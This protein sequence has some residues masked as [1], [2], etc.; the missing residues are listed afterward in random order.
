MS[1]E[2]DFWVKHTQM[3]LNNT[4]GNNKNWVRLDEKGHTGTNTMKGLIRA[5][6]IHNGI[7]PV[8]GEVG[9]KER[10]AL[11]SMNW[12]TLVSGGD[13]NV[14]TI[15]KQLNNEFLD[16]IGVG[17]CDGII[18]RHTAL[19]LIAA[20]QAAE[21]IPVVEDLNQINFGNKTTERF[22]E[23]KFNRSFKKNMGY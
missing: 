20:L 23:L 2:G 14:R 19:S 12:F 1:S 17:P 5:F 16:S 21:G 7:S 10:A 11:L 22:P 8:T 4:F 6:Q 18:S 9:W 15:Q 13:I 3:C